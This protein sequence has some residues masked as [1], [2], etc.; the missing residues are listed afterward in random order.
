MDVN[1]TLV[2][3]FLVP[4]DVATEACAREAE[5]KATGCRLV[6]HGDATLGTTSVIVATGDEWSCGV[7]DPIARPIGHAQLGSEP[8]RIERDERLRQAKRVMGVHLL[9]KRT[10]HYWLMAVNV[11]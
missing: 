10:P 11:T 2:Y 4:Q 6:Y 8:K 1:A 3:G 7:A 9:G 5:I